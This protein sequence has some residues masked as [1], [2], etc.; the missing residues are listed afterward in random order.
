M[1]VMTR[2]DAFHDLRAAQ[3]EMNYLNRMLVQAHRQE[4]QQT[5]H[6]VASGTGVATWAPA[7]D[8]CERTD[9]Y[10]VTV[11]L[12]GVAI[13][14]LEIAFQD[15]LLTIHGE[16]HPTPATPDEQNHLT[17]RRHGQFRR[18]ITLPLHVK[19]DSIEASSEDGVL[20]VTIP[21][22]EQAKPTHITVRATRVL[23]TTPTGEPP[24]TTS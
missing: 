9:S 19:A 23:S 5:G 24:N 3:D 10:I 7:V 16:R 20:R 22:A 12:P 1:T 15:R 13:D 11:E 18:S 2:W 4:L 21:K 17:E 14:D 8:I 6:N